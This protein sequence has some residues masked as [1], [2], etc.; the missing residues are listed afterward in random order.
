MPSVNNQ[1]KPAACRSRSFLDKTP[2]QL[3]FK[4]Q[5]TVPPPTYKKRKNNESL[6]D[7]NNNLTPAIK[8]S[9]LKFDNCTF[10]NC[11]F[12]VTSCKCDT[13]NNP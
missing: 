11:V 4:N 5:S 13:A 3:N 10:N 2:I 9:D 6:D 12:N 8:K 7:Q 1:N